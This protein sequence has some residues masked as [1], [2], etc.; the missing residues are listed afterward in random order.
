MNKA[1]VTANPGEPFTV[2]ERDFDAPMDKVFKALTTKELV[3]QWWVGPGYDVRVEQLDARDGGA[4][5]FVQINKEGKEFAFHGSFHTVSPAMTI[6]TFEF[7]GLPEVG[8]VALE[9]MQLTETDGKTHMR[10][11]ST[12]MSV[13]DRDGML[14]SGME[15]GMQNTYNQ[16]DR[17]LEGVN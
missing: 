8:H 17:V 4:W 6:Q 3:E 1:T 16:L 12:F 5:K 2:I 15:Q 13:A 10:I 9:K 14:A 7:D 11:E